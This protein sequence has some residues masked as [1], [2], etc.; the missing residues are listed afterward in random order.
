MK[1]AELLNEDQSLVIMIMHSHQ[2][3]NNYD[4]DLYVIKNVWAVINCWDWSEIIK[5]AL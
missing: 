4:C 5:N 3:V 2:Q 1:Q